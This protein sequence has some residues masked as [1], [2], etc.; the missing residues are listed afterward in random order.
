LLGVILETPGLA[1]RL[2]EALRP[3]LIAS[4]IAAGRNRVRPEDHGQENHGRATRAE[5][6]E[7]DEL[8]R[9][10]G[11]LLFNLFRSRLLLQFLFVPVRR[12]PHGHLHL[13]H[14]TGTVATRIWLPF[15]F[16]PARTDCRWDAY[17]H[18]RERCRPEQAAG[19]VAQGSDVSVF[20]FVTLTAFLAWFGG[21]D[22]C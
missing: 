4:G 5:G 8:F 3:E 16:P 13:P 7:S 19:H 18:G 12:R 17:G 10:M 2:L 14:F 1:D 15:T 21:T 22:I 6:S 11:G 20:N 9:D